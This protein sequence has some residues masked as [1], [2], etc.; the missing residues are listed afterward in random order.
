MIV[1]CWVTAR[2]NAR[3][4]YLMTM[5]EPNPTYELK[6]GFKKETRHEALADILESIEE[7]R[8]YREHFIKCSNQ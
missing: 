4:A 8:Y 5:C 3:F 2:P 7:L 6:D 1:Q